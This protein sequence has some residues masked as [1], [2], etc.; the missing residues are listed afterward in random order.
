MNIASSSGWQP[1]RKRST[2]EE[3]D[4]VAALPWNLLPT[5]VRIRP[6][7]I[8]SDGNPQ[9]IFTSYKLYLTKYLPKKWPS[10]THLMSIGIRWGRCMSSTTD[11][12]S[13]MLKRTI[14]SLKFLSSSSLSRFSLG[15]KKQA[16]NKPKDNLS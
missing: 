16:C 2:M 13:E 8:L 12:S 10:H 5:L 3:R 9:T 14:S 4:A 1:A 11:P 15:E 7:R 6:Y